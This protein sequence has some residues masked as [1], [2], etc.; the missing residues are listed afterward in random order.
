MAKIANSIRRIFRRTRGTASSKGSSPQP[1]ASCPSKSSSPDGGPTTEETPQTNVHTSASVRID[2]YSLEQ[3]GTVDFRAT[4]QTKPAPTMATDNPGTSTNPAC[5]SSDLGLQ[6]WDQAYDALKSGPT[7]RQLVSKYEQILSSQLTSGFDS[8]VPESQ[9]NDIDQADHD[10]RRHQMECLT[11]KGLERTAREA[12]IKAA[13]G[14]TV[15]IVLSARDIVSSALE[16]MPQLALAWAGLSVALQLLVNPIQQTAENREGIQYVISQM[17]WY[18]GLAGCLLRR[19]ESTSPDTIANAR[20]GMEAQIIDLY[21]ALLSYQMKSVCSYYAH[22]QLIFLRDLVGIDDWKGDLA[23]IREAEQ[24]FRA[25]ATVFSL[26]QVNSYLESLSLRFS[27]LLEDKEAE[28]RYESERACSCE[29][30]QIDVLVRFTEL[31]KS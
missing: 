26:L 3:D 1:Q 17:N 5:S 21:K 19:M 4:P 18:C 12:Q 30:N 29:L 9:A 20:K 13:A 31:I 16:A 8:Q 2:Q 15:D 23:T 27:K 25:D 22:R 14:V 10:K 24:R 11:R 6:L 7:S 28:R